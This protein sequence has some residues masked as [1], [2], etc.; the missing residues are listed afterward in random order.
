MSDLDVTLATALIVVVSAAIQSMTG[1]GFA[2]LAVPLLTLVWRPVDAVAISMVLS[3]LCVVLL[4]L[5][6]RRVEQL[7]IVS[8]L[9]LASLAGLPIG[10]WALS[11]VDVGLL[12]LAIGAVTLATVVMLV[13]GIVRSGRDNVARL[14]QAAAT[15]ATAAGMSVRSSPIKRDS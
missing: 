8:R 9:F 4:W 15:V 2:V 5:Q 12:R 6:V 14:P 11:H 13:S 1:F 7:P 3:T 10:L